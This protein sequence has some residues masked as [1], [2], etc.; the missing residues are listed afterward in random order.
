MAGHNHGS[1]HLPNSPFPHRAIAN[2]HNHSAPPR[3]RN[4][5]MEQYVA[6]LTSPHHTRSN[7][8]ADMTTNRHKYFRWT[9]RT[10]W[11]S[12]A[13]VMLVPAMLGTTA[14]M[15]DVSLV[16]SGEV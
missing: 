1:T 9:R 15:V 3:S 8:R 2:S 5:Q 14:Y 12:F 11:L 7:T 6:L 4:H 16:C 10:A 13:Y